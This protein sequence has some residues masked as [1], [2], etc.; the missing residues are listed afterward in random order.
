IRLRSELDRLGA[1]A[2]LGHDLEIRLG[3]QY[4]SEAV[5]DDRVV[6]GEQDSRL[7]RYHGP[8]P[9]R[10]VA[11][12]S[13]TVQP[14]SSLAAIRSLAPI[15]PARS[16][17]PRMPVPPSPSAGGPDPWSLTANTSWPLRAWS[18]RCA[19]LLPECRATLVSASW[20][21]L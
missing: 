20:A 13:A 5:P 18:E 7:E 6:V 3:V 19:R 17:I 15:R 16:P 12:E 2:R 1:I 11:T 10:A 8:T 9:A 14:P 4:E 21:T